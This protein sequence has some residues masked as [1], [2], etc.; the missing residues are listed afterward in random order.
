MI[1]KHVQT[2]RQQ[3]RQ[4]N[5]NSITSLQLWQLS[6]CPQTFGTLGAVSRIRGRVQQESQKSKWHQI[7]SLNP[8]A[9][10][11]HTCWSGAL[12]V[13][14]DIWDNTQ[15]NTARPLR[16]G[17]HQFTAL[18]GLDIPLA[19]CRDMHED[20][21]TETEAFRPEAKASCARSEVRLRLSMPKARH[22]EAPTPRRKSRHQGVES[23]AIKLVCMHSFWLILNEVNS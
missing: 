22:Q 16:P 10:Q 12:H 19:I 8:R 6:V 23:E 21:Q 2:W 20:L 15:I 14:V 4:N 13:F 9:E 7:W 18:I 5:I 3:I 17:N 11:Q 1:Q